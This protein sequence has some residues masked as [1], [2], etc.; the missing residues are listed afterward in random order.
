M[1]G[2]LEPYVQRCPCLDHVAWMQM[3][4]FNVAVGCTTRIGRMQDLSGRV[5]PAIGT[6]VTPINQRFRQ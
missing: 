2:S 6:R 5:Q 3:Y 1:S 4:L